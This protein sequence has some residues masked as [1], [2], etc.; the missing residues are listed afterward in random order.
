M[1]ATMKGGA[2]LSAF[3]ASLPHN[4][5]AKIL[6]SALKDGAEVIAAGA[7][8][9]CRSDEVRATIV[10]TSST[11]PG[12]VTAKIQT[13]GEGAYKAPWLENGTDPHFISVDPEQSGGQTPERINRLTKGGKADAAGTLLING[14]PVGATVYHPGARPYPFM[15]PALDENEQDAITAIGNHIAAKLT[16]EGLAGPAP[17]ADP[18]E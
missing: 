7:R 6:R 4:L 14:K 1:S 12:I 5:E 15:R 10:T 16:K 9:K 17:A 2:D 8:E 13:K 11:E 3:L 18:E